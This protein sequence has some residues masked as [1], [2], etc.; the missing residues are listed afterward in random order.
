MT[1]SYF[2]K[3]HA[4]THNYKPTATPPSAVIAA[5]D[6]HYLRTF[7]SLTLVTSPPTSIP[8]LLSTFL[9]R[10]SEVHSYL[11]RKIIVI[12]I[13]KT[14]AIMGLSPNQLYSTGTN[15]IMRPGTNATT[16]W[17]RR[18]WCCCYGP[19]KK[20]NLSHLS[21]APVLCTTVSLNLRT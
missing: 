10:G 15:W 2:L 12:K 21:S 1:L 5:T 13:M 4:I 9:K 8:S 18:R 7:A 19:R 14:T 3:E 20:G 17:Q 11:A 6:N 16:H